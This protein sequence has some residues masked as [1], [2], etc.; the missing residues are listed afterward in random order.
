MN[1]YKRGV[2]LWPIRNQEYIETKNEKIGINLMDRDTEQFLRTIKQELTAI[3]K[4]VERH[5]PKIEEHTKP[6]E[7]SFFGN[8]FD[9]GAQATSVK[10]LAEI[11]ESLKQIEKSNIK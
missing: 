10:L 7:E 3:R 8:V 11:A 6:I 2:A 1:V 9:K 4:L 5:L